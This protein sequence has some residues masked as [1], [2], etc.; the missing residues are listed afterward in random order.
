MKN[1]D[2]IPTTDT[3]EIKQLI[4]QSSSKSA[5]LARKGRRELMP[6]EKLAQAPLAVATAEGAWRYKIR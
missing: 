6:F 5:R 4:N 2:D 3:T 1:N